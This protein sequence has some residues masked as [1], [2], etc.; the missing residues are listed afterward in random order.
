MPTRITQAW[1][2]QG[3][4]GIKI[5]DGVTAYVH[6]GYVHY[7]FR[8]SHHGAEHAKAQA[9]AFAEEIGGTIFPY[10]KSDVFV[11][12]DTR[13]VGRTKTGREVPGAAKAKT[14]EILATV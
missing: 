12:Q 1:S 5:E 3:Y 8:T 4:I 2:K 13:G 10:A 7:H 9:H 14:K 6:D 11:V